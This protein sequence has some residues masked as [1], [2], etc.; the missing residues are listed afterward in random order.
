MARIF[1]KG[2]PTE[3]GF[4]FPDGIYVEQNQLE[5]DE[6]QVTQTACQKSKMVL[7]MYRQ[8]P[9]KYSLLFQK[10][11]RDPLPL[12][13]KLDVKYL[14]NISAKSVHFA[15]ASAF[16]GSGAAGQVRREYLQRDQELRQRLKA[17]EDRFA[18]RADNFERFQHG[19]FYTNEER[20]YRGNMSREDYYEE[21]FSRDARQYFATEKEADAI[22]GNL[23]AM[24]Y[25]AA[26]ATG[27]ANA[28]RKRVMEQ[29]E[30]IRIMPVG[31]V[32]Y[33]D[34]EVVAIAAYK[35]PQ[36]I[37][38]IQCVQNM[39]AEYLEG[40]LLTK[41]VIMSRTVDHKPLLQYISA[42]YGI[43]VYEKCQLN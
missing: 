1:G 22:T 42:K 3:D 16:G 9:Q 8:L 19:S 14:Y 33:C 10:S 12:S 37:T 11:F 15:S 6:K 28:S 31:E 30:K 23:R 29:N 2:A 40:K 7:E 24:N 34:G 17:K 36:D 13:K 32:V 43:N 25:Y 21:K 38:E 39:D 41:K 4:S 27:E 20:Y 18:Q 35:D 26:K 5:I